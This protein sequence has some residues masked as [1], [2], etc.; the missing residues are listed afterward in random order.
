MARPD[1]LYAS[2]EEYLAYCIKMAREHPTGRFYLASWGLSRVTSPSQIAILLQYLNAC[3]AVKGE[4]QIIIGAHALMEVSKCARIMMQYRYI[5]WKFSDEVH[6]KYFLYN[7]M[8]SDGYRKT[9]WHG[10][11]GSC[12]L[13]DSQIWNV[14]SGLPETQAK[15]LAKLHDFYFARGVKPAEQIA[16]MNQKDAVE[17]L[18]ERTYF[19]GNDTGEPRTPAG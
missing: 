14:A 7:T 1:R 12:N 4:A 3:S 8:T 18:V 2:Q 9:H 6:A 15:E 5:N 11:L 10:A 16:R 13:S 17:R 19:A